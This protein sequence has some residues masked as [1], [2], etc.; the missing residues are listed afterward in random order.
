MADLPFTVKIDV[1]K[2]AQHVDHQEFHKASRSFEN[3]HAINLLPEGR[4]STLSFGTVKRKYGWD[5]R[6]GLRRIGGSNR[7]MSGGAICDAPPTSVWI[8][9][10][11]NV[12]QRRAQVCVSVPVTEDLQTG[13]DVSWVTPSGRNP[14]R[15]QEWLLRCIACVGGSCRVLHFERKTR[16][17]R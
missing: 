17:N 3:Q 13:D 14:R 10:A 2:R 6:F 4:H 12:L 1:I 11:Q 16:R 5:N 15:I 9:P 8:L 7:S